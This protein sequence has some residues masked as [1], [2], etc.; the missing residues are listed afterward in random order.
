MKFKTR[1][2]LGVYA[3]CKHHMPHRDMKVVLMY[4]CIMVPIIHPQEIIE[5][6]HI[7]A[8]IKDER[9]DKKYAVKKLCDEK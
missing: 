5:N 9:N 4:F 3:L 6:H 2:D 8:I 7:L 1:C